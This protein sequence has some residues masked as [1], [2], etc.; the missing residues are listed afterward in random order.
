MTKEP[1]FFLFFAPQSQ[2]SVKFRNSFAFD[3][4][5]FMNISRPWQICPCLCRK[6]IQK[7]TKL[8]WLFF[9]LLWN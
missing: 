4:N 7:T 2:I 6:F 5:F 3:F 1:I 9:I 8:F